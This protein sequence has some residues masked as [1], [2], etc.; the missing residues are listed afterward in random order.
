MKVT[1]SSGRSGVLTHG[2]YS[3]LALLAPD[4]FARFVSD[5]GL[6]DETF[7]WRKGSLTSQYPR[8]FTFENSA[9]EVRVY[10]Q[11]RRKRRSK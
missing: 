3:P 1:D 5:D 4:G 11:Q 7:Y 9:G 8:C 10:V 6:I 2:F